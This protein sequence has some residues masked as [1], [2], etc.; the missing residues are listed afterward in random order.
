[1]PIPNA[2]EATS[3]CI[4]IAGRRRKLVVP[5]PKWLDRALQPKWFIF[6]QPWTLR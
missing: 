1:M 3:M 4:D 6:G 2:Q 5:R